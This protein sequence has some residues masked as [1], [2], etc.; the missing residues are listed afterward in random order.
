MDGVGGELASPVET[1][2][3]S[4]EVSGEGLRCGTETVGQ[5]EDEVSDLTK[6]YR[7]GGSVST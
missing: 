6:E 3:L 5:R 4:V 2:Q 1:V 7:R